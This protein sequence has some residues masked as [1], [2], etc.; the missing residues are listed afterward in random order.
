MLVSSLIT[1]EYTHYFMKGVCDWK[2]GNVPQSKLCRHGD[3]QSV[4]W[5]QAFGG[6][7]K[8][9]KSHSWCVP[10]GFHTTPCH[11]ILLLDCPRVWNVQAFIK[12]DQKNVVE[13]DQPVPC[14]TVYARQSVCMFIHTL[15][16]TLA[17]AEASSAPSHAYTRSLQHIMLIDHSQGLVRAGQQGNPTEK[18]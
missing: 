7:V 5:N 13:Y 14:V 16:S 1:L 12:F 17:A 3:F 2:C 4:A 18:G 8:A 6:N 11:C 9:W 10:K 15:R